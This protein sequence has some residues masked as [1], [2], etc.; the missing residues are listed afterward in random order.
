MLARRKWM[1]MIVSA[2][3]VFV[4]DGNTIPV[5]GQR[6]GGRYLGGTRDKHRRLLA[7]CLCER[8]RFERPDGPG[9]LGARRPPLL[10][11]IHRRG[12]RRRTGE[13]GPVGHGVHVALGMA[14][15]SMMTS[16]LGERGL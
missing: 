14:K 6:R 9:R 5:N 16:C 11:K 12:K 8:Q 3:P 15:K 13:Q 10:G 1:A 4:A 7:I 2:G